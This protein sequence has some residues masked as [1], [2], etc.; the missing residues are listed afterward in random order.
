M[1]ANNKV[2]TNLFEEN[3]SYI[4]LDKVPQKM[5]EAFLATEDRKFYEH[6]GI[7]VLGIARALLIDL[8]VGSFK[9]G[10]STITQQLVRQTYLSN[11]RTI[12]RKAREAIY[13][14]AV[15]R[16]Y[17]KDQIFEKYLNK[18]YF[19]KQAYGVQAAARAYLG[20]DIFELD[21][22]ETALIAGLVKAP[23]VYMNNSEKARDRRNIVLES[24]KDVGFITPEE[25]KEAAA[26]P[27][28]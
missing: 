15:E 5:K 28:C 13:A 22:A 11:E 16:Y 2:V 18:V 20:K 21:L 4:S 27:V 24:M 6:R 1:S 14:I 9:E 23:S 10:A 19:G 17:T 3:R 7:D 12:A 8:R 26:Q 25:A